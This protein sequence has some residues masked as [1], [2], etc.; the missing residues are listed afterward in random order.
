MDKKY[1]FYH[2]GGSG[3]HGCEAIVRSAVKI[4]GKQVDLISFRPEDDFK[5]G[6]DKCVSSIYRV[7]EIGKSGLRRIYLYVMRHFFHNKKLDYKYQFKDAIKCKD[8]AMISIG[9]DLYCGKDTE[10]LTYINKLV[11][12]R[13]NSIL[14]GC[15]IEPEKLKDKEIIDD[16]HR[17]H[18]IFARESITYN[19]LINAGVKENVFLCAD[20]AFQ[21]DKIELPLPIGFEE[22]N[23]IG[24]N[25]S[26]LVI[27]HE[28]QGGILKKTYDN[29][30]KYIIDNTNYQIAL[31][32]H[33]V[34]DGVSDLIVL[35]EFYERYKDTERVVL[36]QDHNCMELKGYISRCSMFI[37]AR[38]HSTIAAYSSC[39]PTVVVG[40]SVK[41]RGIATDLFGSIDNYVVS[42][43]QLKT[44]DE[45]VNA[46]LWLN[47]NQ[48]AIRN[49]LEK[50]MP[51]YK[52]TCFLIR[53]R[54]NDI[55]GE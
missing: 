29:L 19:A 27:M 22:G 21:L 5:Y 17:Y 3:N 53:E 40:Y 38:T 47:D 6:L 46:F 37:G 32:P 18:L 36:I 9:G 52:E 30:I 48:G 45:L 31:I 41:A 11:S 13:N 49:Q 24:I 28:T 23:T 54:I 12:K 39:V 34:W 16:M 35:N 26:P 20:P 50:I 14:L 43:Q 42:T 7:K 2:H 1:I 10:S 25:V 8:K 44:G 15:S 55:V 33:V 4:L 51:E